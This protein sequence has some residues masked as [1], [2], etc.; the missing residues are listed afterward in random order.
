M[1][2]LEQAE[3]HREELDQVDVSVQHQFDL[4]PE[5]EGADHFEEWP[6]LECGVPVELEGCDMR[7]TLDLRN[8]EPET[9][10]AEYAIFSPINEE[11][12]PHFATYPPEKLKYMMP[13]HVHVEG[14]TDCDSPRSIQSAP[15]HPVQKTKQLVDVIERQDAV[16][17]SLMTWVQELENQSSEHRQRLAKQEKL[18]EETNAF[19]QKLK[20][21]FDTLKLKDGRG[22]EP[23]K[24]PR[25]SQRLGKDSTPQSK[26]TGT[27]QRSALKS[28]STPWLPTGGPTK[29][30]GT[31][32]V[33]SKVTGSSFGGVPSTPRPQKPGRDASTG[34]RH[35]TPQRTPSPARV[36]STE[37]SLMTHTVKSSRMSTG[38]AVLP[39]TPRLPPRPS[40]SPSTGRLATSPQRSVTS[41]QNS[42]R[43]DRAEQSRSGHLCS[44]QDSSPRP[45]PSRSSATSP[46][47]SAR[48]SHKSRKSPHTG[49]TRARSASPP[50]LASKS[51]PQHAG[52]LIFVPRGVSP[53]DDQTAPIVRCR[54]VS[55]RH[56]QDPV[57]KDEDQSSS[58][59]TC[60]M[61]L[62]GR[63]RQPDGQPDRHQTQTSEAAATVAAAVTASVDAIV[64]GSP[65]LPRPRDSPQPS[66][67]IIHNCARPSVEGVPQ[68]V[69]PMCVSTKLSCAVPCAVNSQ[70]TVVSRSPLRLPP[71][72]GP[73]QPGAVAMSP[74]GP[75]LIKSPTDSPIAG[76]SPDSSP[77]SMRYNLRSVCVPVPVPG[78]EHASMDQRQ[79]RAFPQ[80]VTCTSDPRQFREGVPVHVSHESHVSR[81]SISGGVA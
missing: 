68:V 34:K 30:G 80:V 49:V 10:P 21:D 52:A 64:S 41:S 63:E 66:H 25:P 5:P 12:S 58:H 38:S 62:D 74:K 29:P 47:R 67:R 40:R 26:R 60:E 59:S 44:A 76:G 18:N 8:V 15:D 78:W 6:G 32:R 31:G 35:V 79:Y 17:D 72:G 2:E 7:P 1:E 16:I 73:P 57:Q 55:R 27:P 22:I 48:A 43:G 70:M 54:S 19:R 56:G 23:S 14:S 61:S 13:T 51:T 53:T 45:D 33:S 69:A 37:R 50:E 36:A 4:E 28:R 42:V 24:V 75:F 9:S 46:P 3:L 65:C 39:S 20:A 81:L 71:T 11:L 77:P